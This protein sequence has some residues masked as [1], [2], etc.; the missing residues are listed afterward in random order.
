MNKSIERFIKNIHLICSKSLNT[1]N[2]KSMHQLEQNLQKQITPSIN[3]IDEHQEIVPPLICRVCA[4]DHR[5]DIP[6]NYHCHMRPLPMDQE[7]PLDLVVVL[8]LR[9]IVDISET[10]QKITVEA[11][12][13]LFWTDKNI[14]I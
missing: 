13:K 3:N 10:K 5:L 9:N 14:K 12:L 4:A 6:E 1:S 2:T 8:N 11:S 7:K